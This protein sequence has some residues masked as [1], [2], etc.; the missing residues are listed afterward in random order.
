M[1]PP[2]DPVA[3]GREVFHSSTCIACHAIQGTNAQGVLGP[4]LTLLGRRAGIGAGWLENTPENLVR[5]ITSPSAVKPGVLMP[6]VAEAGGNWPPTNL[7][8]EQVT[9]V[10]A[11]LSSLR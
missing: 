10:A 2:A 9:A 4:N 8:E 7:T 11:Y 5:W 1:A 6:G 3:R